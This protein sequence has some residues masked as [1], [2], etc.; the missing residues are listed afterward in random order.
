MFNCY[1]HWAQHLLRQMGEPP[2]TILSRE[3]VTQ[4]D[5]LYM[6]LYRITL[7]P[8]CRGAPS[9]NPG[10]LSQLYADDAAFDGLARRSAQLLKL[11][12]RRGPDRG[13]F[14]EPANSLFISDTPEQEAGAKREFAV[15]GLVLNFVSGSGYLGAYLGLQAELEA[16]VKPQ[17]EAW[18]HGVKEL[19]KIAR[20]H[21]QSAYAGLGMLLQLE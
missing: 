18:A 15:E 8:L 9:S 12:M 7:V 6:V 19:A 11:L 13:Y 5:P 20:R 4:R 14:P 10:L 1:N 21:P 17:V 3:G 2:V 16:W